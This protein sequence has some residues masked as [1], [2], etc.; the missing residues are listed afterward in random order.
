MSSDFL[1]EEHPVRTVVAISERVRISDKSLDVFFIIISS[2]AAVFSPLI[3][4]QTHDYV[5]GLSSAP[6]F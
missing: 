2:L 3:P 5:L 6:G 4:C 1:K